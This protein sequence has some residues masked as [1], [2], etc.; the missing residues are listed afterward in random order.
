MTQPFEQSVEAQER[1]WYYY[2]HRQAFGRN[3]STYA[4]ACSPDGQLVITCTL[5][6]GTQRRLGL[7]PDYESGLRALDYCSQHDNLVKIAMIKLYEHF[8]PEPLANL[9]IEA[10]QFGELPRRRVK[11]VVEVEL[12]MRGSDD[13]MKNYLLLHM[14]GATGVRAAKVN[15]VSGPRIEEPRRPQA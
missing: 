15:E 14:R 6:D 10:V 9:L 11:M 5:P 3:G 13:E 2:A 4:F 7:V 8:N 12:D 1:R